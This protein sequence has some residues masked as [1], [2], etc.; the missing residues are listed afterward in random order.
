MDNTK[1]RLSMFT[2]A[3]AFIVFITIVL[4]T[5]VLLNG[6]IEDRAVASLASVRES[7]SLEF[8]GTDPVG[9]VDDI[10][11]MVDTLDVMDIEKG[12]SEFQRYLTSGQR[13]IIDRV[14]E[15]NF[16]KDTIKKME[17]NSSSYYF[18]Y[19]DNPYVNTGETDTGS[20]EIIL[21]TD[22]TTYKKLIETMNFIYAI[23]LIALVAV[24]YFLGVRMGKMIEDFQEK[25]KKFFQNASH[26]LKTPIMS[27]Q[28][29][30]EGLKLGVI[31]DSDKALDIILDES[32]KMAQLVEELL[33]ISKLESGQIVFTKENVSIYD[34]IIDILTSYAPEIKKRNIKIDLDIENELSIMGDEKELARAVGNIISNAVR[35]T[36][37][38]IKVSGKKENGRIVLEIYNDGEPIKEEELQN[39]FERFFIG[40]KGNTGI[41]LSMAQDII[42]LHKGTIKAVNK[43]DGVSFIIRI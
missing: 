18:T 35:F 33:Y 1:K 3:I 6:Y 29:Y 21:Y 41:G 39:I 2:M 8:D 26:E 36:K 4:L 23:V 5:N 11:L 7:Y 20:P 34:M 9:D 24:S 31:K 16:E 27:I 12:T 25:L 14:S 30:A 38:Q 37:S 43:D 13:E 10:F 22:V 40:E 28:G 17:I 42:K 15:G 19:F 32:H